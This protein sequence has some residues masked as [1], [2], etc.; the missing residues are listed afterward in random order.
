VDTIQ[1]QLSVNE[2][3]RSDY[4]SEITFTHVSSGHNVRLEFNGDDGS[5]H[6]FTGAENFGIV[7]KSDCMPFRRNDEKAHFR[8][9]K[10]LFSKIPWKKR[11]FRIE[12]DN[13]VPLPKVRILRMK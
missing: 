11:G 1:K 2:W 8:L 12:D 7:I 9:Y 3:C 13:P 4:C 10:E 5:E 6:D